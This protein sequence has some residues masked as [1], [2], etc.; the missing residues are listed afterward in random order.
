MPRPL[1]TFL[2]AASLLLGC[3]KSASGDEHPRASDDKHEKH[4]GKHKGDEKSK[5]KFKIGRINDKDLKESSGLAASRKYPGVYWTHNDS[6]NGPFLFA[7]T[8]EGKVLKEFPVASVRNTDW[9]AIAIDEEGH[10]YIGDVGN[11]DHRRDRVQVYRVDEPDPNTP[12]SKPPALRVTAVWRLRYPD[13]PFDAE[14]LVVYKGK[15][16]VISKLV[17]G[18]HAGVYAFDASAAPRD[19]VSMEH[20][21]DLP[22]RTPVTDACVSPDGQRLAVMTATGPCLFQIDG[23]MANA[24]K[25]TPKS[26]TYFDPDNLNMEGICFTPEGLLASSEQG[27]MLLFAEEYF[28]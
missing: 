22:V 9:E 28:K 17:N 21:F 3:D 15:G 20:V 4:N 25:V 1:V 2:L 23:E 7:I 24:A 6:G 5:P 16:Y 14:S 8:R 10:L 11:N 19:A 13:K 27:Q 12:V 18:Q 26:V